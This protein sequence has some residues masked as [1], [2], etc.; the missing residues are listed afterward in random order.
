MDR[1]FDTLQRIRQLWNELER[2]K[3]ETAEYKALM[4]KIRVLSAEYR[5]L[6]DASKKHGES[7]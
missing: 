3:P 7:K 1:I 6:I 5:A 2:T 4:E